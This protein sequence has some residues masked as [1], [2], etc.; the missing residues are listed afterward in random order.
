MVQPLW[1][2]RWV[3]GVSMRLGAVVENGRTLYG[4][5]APET[6]ANVRERFDRIRAGRACYRCGSPV[7]LCRCAEADAR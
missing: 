6:A 1:F 3:P 7:G 5:V 4:P 2:Y